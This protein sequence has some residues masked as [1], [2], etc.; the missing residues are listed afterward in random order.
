MYIY[1]ICI[2]IYI[3]IHMHMHMHVC[4][5]V[6][7]CVQR[8]TDLSI[9]Q[10]HKHVY[11]RATFPGSPVVPRLHCHSSVQVF[12]PTNLRRLPAG[13]GT[14]VEPAASFNASSCTSC[15]NVCRCSCA[16]TLG[17]LQNTRCT[18]QQQNKNDPPTLHQPFAD[19]N[20]SCDPSLCGRP[21]R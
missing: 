11:V 13:A 10:V 1:I 8:E 7:V 2:Y 9:Y 21:R 12:L 6:C 20:H 14:A 3:H 15:S 4:V 16:N 17:N 5:Y 19:H 18:R